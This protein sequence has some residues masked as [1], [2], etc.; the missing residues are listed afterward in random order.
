MIQLSRFSFNHLTGAPTKAMCPIKYPIVLDL[1][2]EID[3]SVSQER[4]S[5]QA[6]IDHEGEAA[7]SGHYVTYA[8]RF[9]ETAKGKGKGKGQG[10]GQGK[11]ES[12]DRGKGQ[13][14]DKGQQGKGKGKGSVQWF[15]INDTVISQVSEDEVL[16]PLHLSETS[17]MIQTPYILL[18]QKTAHLIL[19]E[20][21]TRIAV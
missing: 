8:R 6:V 16:R 4:Y 2:F 17:R 15:K 3:G 9:H 1:P 11:A 21:F 13:G 14:Q 7:S 12:K 5:L 20:K 10:K 19:N 18:C